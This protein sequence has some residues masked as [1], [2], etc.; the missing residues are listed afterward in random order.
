MA[1]TREEFFNKKAN[2]SLWDVAVSIKR[3]NPLPLDRDSVFENYAALE[4]YAADVL[5]YPGQI[6]AVVEENSTGIY[7]LDQNL[8]IQPVGVVPSGDSKTIEVTA[9]GMI[10]LLGAASAENGTIPMIEEGV[11]A[12][13]TLEDIGAG[14]GNDNTTYEFDFSNEKITVTPKHNGL[15]QDTIELDLSNFITTEELM[16]ELGK[17]VNNDTTYSI[18]EGEKVLK[19][20]DTIFSTELG[21][22][23]ENG[24]ISLTGINGEVIAEFSDADFIKDSVLEDVEYD[25]AT[26]EIVFTWKTEGEQTKTDRV[27]VTDFVQTYTAGNGLELDN[28]EFAVKVDTE[29]ETFL[30]IDTNG[31]KL[32]GIQAA[33]NSAATSAKDEAIADAVEKYATK[34]Y[35]GTIPDNYTETNLISYINK[36]AEETL[37]AAQGGSS[38][39]AASVKQQLDNY[40]SEND[41][42]VNANTSAIETINEKLKDVEANAEVNIIE[43]VKVN[44][45]ALEVSEDKSVNVVVPGA[46]TD[47][48]DWTTLDERVTAAKVQA[49]KGVSDAA[50]AQAKADNNSAEI[51]AIGGR[52]TTLETDRTAHAGRLDVLETANAKHAGEYTA[53]KNIVDGHVTAIASKA[54]A[55]AVSALE[56]KVSAS[57][58]AIKTISETTIPGVLTE[59]EK[60]ANAAD[61]YTK[62]EINAITGTPVEGKTL[63]DMISETQEAAEYDDTEVRGLIEDNANAIAAIYTAGSEG[64]P[65]S[66]VLTSEITHV[67]GLISAEANRADG[68]E[69]DLDSRL[70]TVEAFWQE[71]VRDENEKNVIDTLKEIQ[72]YITSDTTG[73]SAMAAKI[74]EHT[75]RLDGIF[76][77]ADGEAPAS[78]MLVTEIARVESKITTNEQAIAVINHSETG[79]LATAKKYTD[80]QITAIPVAGALLGLVKSSEE[81]NKIKIETD[82][83]MTI[84]RVSTDNLYVP[85]ESELILNGGS[86]I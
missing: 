57:D 73:A 63:V 71:A 53:L 48:E 84:N 79:I 80:E 4:T 86:A 66:G 60:K 19:L 29:S 27:S 33:I 12:W 61:V 17:L 83:T 16:E 41:T 59:V 45:V 74:N 37:A 22:K 65:A 31:I 40:K 56:L 26:Q 50:A 42:K 43:V 32:T 24:M 9:N 55:S 23:H 52:L 77:A 67:E 5:A 76:V 85:E 64:A 69:K 6:V 51:T 18:A 47:L 28:N 54:E 62:T 58:N 39:T 2:A 20:N 46:L 1:I 25:S 3:G 36:K 70:Q 44:G 81:D 82:G 38:E 8:A 11:L 34:T 13:K 14:D 15:A 75:D 68:V 10:S 30:S 49:D 35:V 78:G 7:Y 21:L 72:D